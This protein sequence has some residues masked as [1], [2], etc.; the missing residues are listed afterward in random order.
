MK[1]P[2]YL[3]KVTVPFQKLL[4]QSPALLNCI[5]DLISLKSTPTHCLS[6]YYT[7]SSLVLCSSLASDR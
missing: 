1:N 3:L 4:F 7:W 2:F 5:R 6:V